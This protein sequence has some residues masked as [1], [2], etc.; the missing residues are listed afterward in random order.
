MKQ[1]LLILLIS[2]LSIHLFAVDT[3]LLNFESSTLP[4]TVGSW[5]NYSKSGFT[6]STWSVTNPKSDAINSSANCYKI[7]KKSDDPYWTG[8]E[9]T[10]TSAIPITSSNQ[11]LHVFVYKTTTSRIAITYT[12]EGGNQSYDA[13]QSN[14]TMGSWIDYVVTI[15]VNTR[16]KTFSIKIG[17]DP[18]EY[19]FD[20]VVLSDNG[21]SLSRAELTID[22][23]IKRQVIEGWGAS[24]CWWANIMGGFSD[25]KIKTICDWI[26][27]PVNGLN[28]N[29]FRFNI[30]GGD[31]PTH[32]HMRTDG[33]DMPGYKASLIAP[34]DWSQD[35]NQRKII[36]QLIA[37]RIAKSG[38]NDIQIVAF[39]NSPPYWMTR[40]GCSAG[41]VEGNVGNLKSDMFDDFADYL[42]EVTKYYHDNWGI[43][44]NYIE[45][46]NEPDGGWWKAF[47]GQE[48]CYFSNADQVTM[49]R[50][51]YAKLAE[52]Q[53]L[54]YA[55]ITANDANNLDNGY[56]SLLA[57]QSAG[58]IIPKIDMV[59]VHT[60]GGNNRSGL[61]NW[62]KNNQ[63]KL[64]QS[65]SG[66]ISVGGTNEHQ[67]M[68]MA[69]RIITD[70]N[71]M[72]CT[73]WCDWQI[74]GTGSPTNNPWG[75]IISDYNDPYNP[76]TRCIN[77]YIR[78]QYSR[79]LKAGYILIGNSLQNAITAISPDEME[80]VL[81]ISNQNSYTQKYVI[82]LSK[83]SNFGKVSQVRT[84]A[85][86]T[87]GV[88]N[89]LTTFNL[90][91]N[92]LS[93]DALSESVATFIIPVNQLPASTR[94]KEDHKDD[95]YYSGGYLHTNF[96]PG[97]TIT[98]AV[99]NPVGQLVKTD[100]Q[101]PSQGIHPLHLANGIYLVSTW[102]DHMKIAT[103]IIV[104]E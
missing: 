79:Y 85:D 77:F 6:A 38:V 45:P 36:Q 82:D 102:I 48:G 11:Y 13:W 86:E 58:D 35:A 3:V 43:S 60:Y 88:K 74:G 62:A 75:L 96:V 26:T 18:G 39:S 55:Q 17:D 7:V 81:V 15:P 65:E 46:F 5:L 59:S 57:Y 20:Q 64:W 16:L 103:K 70:M 69:D 34:Y 52:K 99:Y 97:Q 78:A 98:V 1:S 22:P 31:D 95:F 53:M 71:D 27:D 67:I 10:L 68:A 28:M 47:G 14:N 63:K 41:S 29:I 94:I 89:S 54:S 83:F 44:F 104:M 90:T 84:R 21:T 32:H 30:G 37:S 87:L 12:P 49:I 93:Y 76:I 92:S 9:V 8:L 42:T 80:L 51:L 73:A 61:A 23:E 4:G 91:G 33:G 101:V 40:S 72:K 19:F 50:E 56:N 24:L 25:S 100:H 2:L 66:P